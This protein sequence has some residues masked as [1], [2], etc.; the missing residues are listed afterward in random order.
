MKQPELEAAILEL[1]KKDADVEAA[2]EM[3]GMPGS[4]IRDAGLETLV[5]IIVSQQISTEAAASIMN[6][7][8]DLLPGMTA[9]KLMDCDP[10]SLRKAGLSARKTEY[11]QSLAQAVAS[12]ELPLDQLAQMNDEEVIKIIT[13]LRGFGRWS[14]EIYLM[15]SLGRT[16]IFPA[17][18]LALQVALG[19]LKQLEEKPTARQSRDITAA[20]APLRSAGAIFLWHYY[21]GAPT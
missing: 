18:D 2:L 14:A 5:S 20:W 11:C 12:G 15:F 6:R 7:L 19:R 17:D 10:D 1:A 3:V 16:D 9:A 13:A 4:R 8:R 21:R